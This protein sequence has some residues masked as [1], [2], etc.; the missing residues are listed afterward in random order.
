MY[1]KMSWTDRMRYEEKAK[2]QRQKQSARRDVAY[3]VK[4]G[5][6]KKEAC[7]CGSMNV[8]AHHVD[9]SKPLEVIWACPKHHGELDV[10]RRELESFDELSPEREL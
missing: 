9:Y 5:R 6:L 2:I 3:A 1:E 7:R 4:T 8:Q 10:M